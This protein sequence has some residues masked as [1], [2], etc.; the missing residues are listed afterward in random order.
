MNGFW[1]LTNNESLIKS[2]AW[3]PMHPFDVDSGHAGGV[4]VDGVVGWVVEQE[5]RDG[6]EGGRAQQAGVGGGGRAAAAVKTLEGGREARDLIINVL[7]Q[8]WIKV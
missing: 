5:G 7:H 6:K 3:Q 1:P 2:P 8:K 4:E